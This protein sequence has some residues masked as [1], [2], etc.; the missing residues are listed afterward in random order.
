MKTVVSVIVPVFNGAKQIIRCLESIKKQTFS[1]FECLII[2]DGSV[3]DSSEVIRNWITDDRFH[4]YH[5]DNTGVAV[6]R[7]RGISYA[8]GDFLAFV[9]QDDYVDPDYLKH[10]MEAVDDDTDIVVTGYSRVEEDG[11]VLFKVS[12]K[13]GI[14]SK[15]IVTAPWA[16]LYRTSFIKRHQIQF[17][18]SKIGEDVYFNMTA[19]FYTN[20][21]RIAAVDSDYRWV[22]NTASVSNSSQSEAGGTDPRYL[23]D[24]I[25]KARPDGNCIPDDILEYYFLRYCVWYI[26]FVMRKSPL[27]DNL[28]WQNSLR[29]WLKE[30]FPDYLKNKYIKKCPEGEIGKYHLAVKGWMM[31]RQ[32]KLDKLITRFFSKK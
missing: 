18:D 4:L 5:Q 24:S 9:D 22:F 12:L 19:V 11:K 20:N 6:T 8:R 13:K 10:L 25:Y 3:D 21:I 32:I 26:L 28:E 23:L 7:N 1:D 15:L 29:K 30:H 31:L 27:E 16:H 14:F 17:L 2:D